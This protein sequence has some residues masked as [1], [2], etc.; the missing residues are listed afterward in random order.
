MQKKYRILIYRSNHVMVV[1]SAR[2]ILT[3]KAC[4]L[5]QI[6][7]LIG[8]KKSLYHFKLYLVGISNST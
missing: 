4:R 2:N 7:L 8:I 1:N 6:E 5:F 3:T